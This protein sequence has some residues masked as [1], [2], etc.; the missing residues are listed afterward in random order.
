MLGLDPVHVSQQSS[1]GGARIMGAQL[2]HHVAPWHTDPGEALRELQARFLAESYDLPS[3]VRDHL[4]SIR[5]AV[6]V[7]E[8]EG[9]EYGILGMYRAELAMLEEIASGP[10]PE[11]P[12]QQIEL[13]RKLYM[14][15]G[16]GIGNILDV[17]GISELREVNA[18]ERLTEVEVARL[19]GESYPTLAQARQAV[20][21]INGELGRGESVCFAFYEGGDPGRPAGWYFVGNTID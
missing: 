1:S 10:L 18:A 6:R 14:N 8:A 12:L 20:N 19:V 16:E 7:T 13:M 21:N 2:W 15:S 9:D 3:L 5:E 11:V 17:E 4:G